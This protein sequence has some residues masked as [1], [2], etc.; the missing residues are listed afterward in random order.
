MIKN[1]QQFILENFSDPD[2]ELSG[3]VLIL[4]NSIL[5]VNA[6]KNKNEPN[7]WSIPKG[8]IENNMTELETAIEELDQEANIQIPVKRF[9]NAIKD[10]LHYINK[11]GK[12]KYLVY[13]VIQINETDIDF[14]L[15][16]DMI[17]KYYLNKDEI[18]EAGFFSKEDAVELIDKAQKPI[19]KYLK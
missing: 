3:V 4:N 1:F 10:E 15:Y 11:N 2:H 5:L 16:N 17:L 13:F 14:K 19:L 12:K 9:R 6:K 7:K 8:H 18:S